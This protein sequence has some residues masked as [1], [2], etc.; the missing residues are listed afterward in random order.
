MGDKLNGKG[1]LERKLKNLEVYCPINKK[2]G[3]IGKD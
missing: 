1:A 3:A 2:K